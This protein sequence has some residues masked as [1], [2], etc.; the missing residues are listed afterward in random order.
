M[1]NTT[2]N[3][4]VFNFDA[5]EAM[6]P[7]GSI[8]FNITGVEV[9]RNCTTQYGIRDRAIVEYTF[10]VRDD[11]NILKPI[12]IKQRY[13]VSNHPGSRF[14]ELVLSAIGRHV[15]KV[16]DIADLVGV[17]GIADITHYT[18]ENG[19]VYEQVA[20]IKVNH[21]SSIEGTL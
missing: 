10:N 6:I 9:E 12:V 16:F 20:S 14:D 19:D 1:E 8:P 17:T 3:S 15:G 11:N 18:R 13:L 5:R 4:T 2:N 21:N 7:K